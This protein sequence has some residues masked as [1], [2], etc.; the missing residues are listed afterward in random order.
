MLISNFKMMETQIKVQ[1]PI[2][3]KLIDKIMN[4]LI[5]DLVILERN[6]LTQ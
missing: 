2:L 6:Y 1:N 4:K 5:L 3:M